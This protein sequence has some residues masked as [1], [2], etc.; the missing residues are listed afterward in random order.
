MLLRRIRPNKVFPTSP[1]GVSLPQTDSRR[2][3]GAWSN[4][5]TTTCKTQGVILVMSLLYF[6]VAT[7]SCRNMELRGCRRAA[8][9]WAKGG[10]SFSNLFDL[11]CGPSRGGWWSVG[12]GLQLP[13]ERRGVLKDSGRGR[14]GL[15]RRCA[16]VVGASLAMSVMS[17]TRARFRPKTSTKELHRR[18]RCTPR[19]HICLTV[20]V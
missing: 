2:H 13:E 19:K 5:Q 18:T 1:A 6:F 9:T 7:R 20:L 14:W 10:M 11:S 16:W 17:S 8:W 15:S 12:F 4:P 3:G